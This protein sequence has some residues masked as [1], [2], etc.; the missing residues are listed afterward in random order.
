[1]STGRRHL[2]D[3]ESAIPVAERMAHSEELVCCLNRLA[4]TAAEVRELADAEKHL[5][6]ALSV[7]D[8]TSH[9]SY[10]PALL[11]NLAAIYL[12]QGAI[13]KYR[14]V[15]FE[16]FSLSSD[17]SHRGVCL[18]SAASICLGQAQ[19]DAALFL[20]KRAAELFTQVNDGL[21]LSFALRLQ[22]FA[23]AERSDVKQ[24]VQAWEQ[25]LI[26]RRKFRDK[27]GLSDVMFALGGVFSRIGYYLHSLDYFEESLH[28]SR[29]IGDLAGVALSQLQISKVQMGQNNANAAINA[30]REAVNALSKLKKVGL[31]LDALDALAGAL[32]EAGRHAEAVTVMEQMASL[33]QQFRIENPPEILSKLEL[34][35]QK[36]AENLKSSSRGDSPSG[37]LF[38]FSIPGRSTSNNVDFIKGLMSKKY[39]YSD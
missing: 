13:Q 21:A 7:A 18:L 22:G 39:Q 11:N 34:V 17:D 8:L 16:S 3:C 26:L 32:V 9:S 12:K 2:R 36:A 15:A 24:C 4:V 28:L 29:E 27:L 14:V 23:H 25:S 5:L 6:R 33:C 10:R 20:S 31:E 35:R 1:M 30:A 37:L 19:H 38:R